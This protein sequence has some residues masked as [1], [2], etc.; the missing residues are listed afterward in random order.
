ME[1]IQQVKQKIRNRLS[2]PVGHALLSKR[3]ND[4]YIAAFPRSGSTWLRTILV[5]ILEPEAQGN[6]DVFNARIP[7]VSIRNAS[8]INRLSS[9]RLIMTHSCWRPSMNK[10]VYLV[11]DGRD[12][13]ISSYHYH[14]TR[15]G[16]DMT[17]EDYYQLYRR[18]IYGR[19]WQRHTESFLLKGQQVLGGNLLSLRFDDLKLDTLHSIRGVCAFLN[20][21]ADDASIEHAISYA[22][23][24][25]A[26][27]I[28]RQRQG[29][30]ADKNASFYRSGSNAQWQQAEYAD[31]MREFE[32]ESFESL[33]LAKFLK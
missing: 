33:K 23:L 6:P 21:D 26:K 24:E 16:Q 1:P 2:A 3:D 9:P 12:A 27:K 25:N 22:S 7:A 30:L 32:R 5:N 8:I 20:I 4:A 31:V 15:E 11:R 13:F 10:V 18:E 14:V 29:D 17:L 19:T 28:E